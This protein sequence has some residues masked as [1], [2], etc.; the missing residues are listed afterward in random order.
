TLEVSLVVC[1]VKDAL[2]PDIKEADGDEAEVD[3][4]LVEAEHARAGDGG[5]AAEDDRPRKHEDGLDIEQDE[6]HR[7]HVEADSEAAPRIADHVHAALVRA[8]LGAG[9]FVLAD[10]EG[11]PHHS[12]GQSKS[13][14]DLKHE[15]KVV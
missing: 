15:W 10:E 6:E 7:D 11:S 2:L 3:Q 1:P 4:H 12:A 9:V 8:G 13:N 14:Q 5:Q